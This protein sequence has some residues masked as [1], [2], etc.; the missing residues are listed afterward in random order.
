MGTW[1]AVVLW[2]LVFAV[3]LAPWVYR[4]WPQKHEVASSASANKPMPKLPPLETIK[5]EVFRSGG[6]GADGHLCM[7]LMY[8]IIERQLRQ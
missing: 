1:I 7:A 2:V 4:F 5:S 3:A 8:D 6:S